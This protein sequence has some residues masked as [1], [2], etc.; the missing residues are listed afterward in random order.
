M[1]L[2]LAY[3]S[4]FVD[5]Q[6]FWP[7]A[8]FGL[9]YKAWLLVNIILLILWISFKKKL[10]LYNA[11]ALLIGIQYAAREYQWHDQDPKEEDLA[12]MVFNTRVQQVYDG[13]NTSEEI[14]QFL[15]DS[16][17]DVGIL[18]EWLDKQGTIDK[19]SFPH[20]Q[21]VAINT[22]RD[23]HRYGLKLVS[24]YPILNWERLEYPHYSNN[25][26]AY[27]DLEV[28]E[29]IIRV[30]GTHL[31]SNSLV[32]SD[33]QKFINLDFDQEY[34]E[35][36]KSVIGK[37]R[38]AMIRRAVQVEKIIEVIEESPYPVIV[39]GD[40]NDTPQSYAYQKL[41]GDRKDAFVSRGKGWGSTY[42]KP[43]PLLRIDFMLYDEA[44][45]CTAFRTSDHIE[46]D[47]KLLL[48]HF[49]L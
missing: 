49:K 25:V 47:H 6:D 42:L 46:S 24:K 31:Q 44:F 18:V 14:N 48:A 29:Q 39:L 5:P 41:K 9:T 17:V 26:T 34:K 2:L 30:I 45:E 20:Q 8:F 12:I 23:R 32:A 7:I 3:L 38:S 43:F 27:F 11:L 1:G 37:M 10:W 22:S 35:H 16:K 21:M 15:M 19:Q 36:A 40:F 13:S 33:Y 4:P 28:G